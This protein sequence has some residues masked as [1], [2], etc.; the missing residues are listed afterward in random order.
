MTAGP[1]SRLQEAMR[2]IYTTYPSDLTDTGWE[3]MQQY[4]SIARRHS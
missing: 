1:L 3:R 4:L 2:C